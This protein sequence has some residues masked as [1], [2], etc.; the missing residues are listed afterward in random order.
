MSQLDHQLERLL[1][2]AARAPHPDVSPLSY[3]TQTRALAAWR[4]AR[5]EGLNQIP[6]Q[7]WRAGLV[8]AFAAASLAVGLSFAASTRFDP[9]ESDPYIASDPGL[10][11]AF[12]TGWLP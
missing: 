9:D 3:A 7:T 11:V 2:S 1:R 5:S 4:A 6:L 10:A 12:S 8:A